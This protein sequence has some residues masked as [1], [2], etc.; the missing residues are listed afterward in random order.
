MHGV[1]IGAK[2]PEMGV[3]DRGL[4]EVYMSLLERSEQDLLEDLRSLP[5]PVDWAIL[6]QGLYTDHRVDRAP[7]VFRPREQKTKVLLILIQ[8]LQS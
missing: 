3:L 2:L 1:V 5:Y 7:M 6:R 4:L 8:E